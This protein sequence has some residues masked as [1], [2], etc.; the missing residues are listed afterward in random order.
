MNEDLTTVPGATVSV[1][2]AGT[3]MG[4]RSMDHGTAPGAHVC[5]VA[6]V[7]PTLIRREDAGPESVFVASSGKLRSDDMTSIAGNDGF[8]TV[9][10]LPA[11]ATG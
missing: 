10:V 5:E 9:T 1:T 8:A 7:P 4:I 3:L 6:T 2:P 11:T